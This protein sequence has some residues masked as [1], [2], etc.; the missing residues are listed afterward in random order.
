MANTYNVHFAGEVITGHEPA[1]VRKKLGKLFGAN[2]ATLDKLFSGTQRL[3]KKG[4]DRATA[5][6]YRAAMQRAGA[7]AIIDPPLEAEQASAADKIA[8]LAAAPEDARYREQPPQPQPAASES[9]DPPSEPE[10]AP[11]PAE[12]AASTREADDSS[13]ELRPPESA[14]LEEHERAPEVRREVDTSALSVDEHGDRLAPPAPTP[15][16]APDTTHLGMAEVGAAVPNLPSGEA[17]ISPN[18]D[19]IDLSPEGTDFSDCRTEAPPA[20]QL[21]LS[22]IDVAAEGEDLLEQRYRDAPAP[23]APDTNHLSIEE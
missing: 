22:G 1:E 23:P 7:V 4:C 21:D 20:P 17:P 8:A 14:V 5:E 3:I 13:L 9:D 18:I 6:K 2:D 19:A 15:P 12:P 10:A 16:P 11:A